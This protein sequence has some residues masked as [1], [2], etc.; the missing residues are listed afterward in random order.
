MANWLLKTEP[1]SFSVQDLQRNGKTAWEGVRNYQAR[2][3]IR[4]MAPGDRAFI[5]H[6]SCKN[7]GIAGIA[8]VLSAPTADP[9]QF[10]PHSPYFDAKSTAEQ[11]RWQ[12][13]E[14]GFVATLAQVLPL[15]QLKANPALAELPLVQKG[16][17]LSVMPVSDQQ[18][19]TIMAMAVQKTG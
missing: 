7:V 2:N 12:L 18:W 9:T 16:N 14:V 15:P 1:D 19:Q 8:E 3:F 13:V 6:S 4:Q 11:P 5:Y 17:R 10:D